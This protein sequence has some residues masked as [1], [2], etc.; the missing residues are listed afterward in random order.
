MLFV[1]TD[2]SESDFEKEGTDMSEASAR[3][4]QLIARRIDDATVSVYVYDT[5]D[6][7]SDECR[8]RLAAGE[9]R[10]VVLSRTQTGGRGRSGKSF[11]SPNG[12]LYMSVAFPAAPDVTGLTCRAAVVAAQAIEEIAGVRCG[13]KWVNDLYLNGKKV[14]GILAE[15]VEGGVIIGVGVNLAPMPL[16]AE[17]EN[18]VGFLGCGE[19]RDALAAEIAAA[20][21]RPT[22]QGDCMAAYRSRSIVPGRRIRCRIGQRE[23]SALAVDIADDGSLIVDGPN[24]RETVFCGEI[25]PLQGECW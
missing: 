12:G 25:F 24:G 18:I 2:Q 4:A 1:T 8:R 21:L 20:L 17:L 13:I 5:I 3:A 15:T 7:T 23:F 11:F 9:R 10:C 6:S 16:P 22:A 19:A 14:C